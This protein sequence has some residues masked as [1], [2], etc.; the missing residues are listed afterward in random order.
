MLYKRASSRHITLFDKTKPCDLVDAAMYQSESYKRGYRAQPKPMD[1]DPFQSLYTEPYGDQYWRAAVNGCEEKGSG[2]PAIPWYQCRDS[3]V[4]PSDQRLSNASISESS[5]YLSQ[6]CNEPAGGH[7]DAAS[8]SGSPPVTRDASSSSGSYCSQRTCSPNGADSAPKKSSFTLPR[9]TKRSKSFNDASRNVQHARRRQNNGWRLSDHDLS[10]DSVEQAVLQELSVEIVRSMEGGALLPSL[11]GRGLVGQEDEEF[12]F[13]SCCSRR[14]QNQ[15]LLHLVS[16]QG[17]LGFEQFVEA[18]AED[19]EHGCNLYLANILRDAYHKGLATWPIHSVILEVFILSYWRCSLCHTGDA[20]TPN[21]ALCYPEEEE[22]GVANPTEE[23]GLTMHNVPPELP[24]EEQSGEENTNTWPKRHGV[25]HGNHNPYSSMTTRCHV[26]EGYCGG[27]ASGRGEDRD[28]AVLYEPTRPADERLQ[29]KKI[30]WLQQRTTL[31]H[32]S[33]SLDLSSKTHWREHR[34]VLYSG[35]LQ[36]GAQPRFVVLFTDLVLILK[37]KGKTKGK[38]HMLLDWFSDH[39]FTTKEPL[40][41]HRLTVKKVHKEKPTTFCL[42]YRRNV[43]VL[44]ITLQACS[45]EAK[46]IWVEQLNAAIE[47]CTGAQ[48]QLVQYAPQVSADS[49]GRPNNNLIVEVRGAVNLFPVPSSPVY[50]EVRVG[51]V[52]YCTHAVKGA[53]NPQWHCSIGFDECFEDDS[54]QVTVRSE[55]SFSPDSTLGT[56]RIQLDALLKDGHHLKGPF[57]MSLGG[58]DGSIILGLKAGL[59]TL[60]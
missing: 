60:M 27:V 21:S 23:E 29:R 56:A 47:K 28:V 24:G 13:E 45:V 51:G 6:H 19:H 40:L 37:A 55:N 50:C 11:K 33:E 57:S 46:A 54:I 22:R 58:G 34:H 42:Q 48:A 15:F 31:K 17:R 26:R 7:V 53:T 49:S 38:N 52:A 30:L 14:Q 25:R 16:Q 35:I 4:P 44:D 41:L 8:P 32:C 2:E 12:L 10:T 5:G 59:A 18:L 1:P 36:K 3:P 39:Q 43:D 20:Q 9:E